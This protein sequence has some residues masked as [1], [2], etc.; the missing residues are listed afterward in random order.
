MTQIGLDIGSKTIKVVEVDKSGNGF[1]LKASGVVGYR[2]EP[3]EKLTDEKQTAAVSDIV[4]KLFKAAGVS[5]RDV[6][7]ALPENL[8]F[9]R[10]IR[11]PLLTDQEVASAIKWEAEQYIPM[12]I[13]EA[14]VQHQI[15]SRVEKG[16]PPEVVVLLVA[17]PRVLVEKYVSVVTEAKLN[18][19]AV[20]TEL[21]SM[22]RALA[23]A[24][25]TALLI[26]FGSRSVD[27]AIAKN[28]AFAFSR[29]IPSA[30]E[31]L[32]RALTQSLGVSAQEAEEYK[33]AYGLSSSQLEGK[34]KGALEPIVRGL[35]DEIK[36]AI[37]FYQ[38]EEKGDVPLSTI[39]S[40]G[41]AGM[42]ELLSYLSSALASE[43]V[44]AN[45]F[46]KL[47][48]DA[49]TWTHIAPYAPLYSVAVGLAT[50]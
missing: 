5:G 28:G 10:T 27:I 21:I 35:V 23:P 46:T 22:V 24:N 33:R 18:V 11:L 37:H 7:I 3:I 13:K 50:R 47:Q 38:S 12:P 30:G 32:T 26:D 39:I 25:Q 40:G 9:T 29:S 44:I 6:A 8:V 15:I 17:A 19:V 2:G 4:S 1:S 45:P 14:I 16:G 36:K 20:E 31:A 43:V 41:T 34:I 42:P 49:G 48:V